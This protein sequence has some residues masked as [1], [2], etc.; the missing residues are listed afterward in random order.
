MCKDACKTRVLIFSDQTLFARSVAHLLHQEQDLQILGWE[1]E[2]DRALQ[3]IAQAPPDV[4]ILAGWNAGSRFAQATMAIL[5]KN[6][7]VKVVEVNLDSNML[8]IYGKELRVVK[9]VRDLL[10]A[11]QESA[12]KTAAPIGDSDD[13]G[14]G[15]K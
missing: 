10:E 14:P 2:P 1:T 8:L 11:I 6:P 12:V 7:T 9:E 4:V 13:Q 15:V 5:R 3:S